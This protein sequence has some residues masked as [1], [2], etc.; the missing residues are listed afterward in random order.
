MEKHDK[1]ATRLL[2]KHSG[3]QCL[4]TAAEHQGSATVNDQVHAF[5][6]YIVLKLLYLFPDI[7]RMFAGF[8]DLVKQFFWSLSFDRRF[9]VALIMADSADSQ[10]SAKFFC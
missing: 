8:A 7:C 10:L 4:P 1:S 2:K 9:S 5:A 3:A 6:D